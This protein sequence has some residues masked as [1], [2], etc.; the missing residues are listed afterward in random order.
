MVRRLFG[1]L[2]KFVH[3]GRGK[4]PRNLRPAALN[5]IIAGSH[6]KQSGP[7]GIYR[8]CSRDAAS[9]TIGPGR[10]NEL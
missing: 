7:A 1:T 6:L 8:G 2:R 10:T 5:P 9:V 3:V 4:N